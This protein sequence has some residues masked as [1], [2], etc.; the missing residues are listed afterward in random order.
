M[1]L[2]FLTVPNLSL[3]QTNPVSE[4][5]V[6]DIRKLALENTPE[7]DRSLHIA[8]RSLFT[9]HSPLDI[10]PYQRI[11]IFSVLT[12]AKA[13]PAEDAAEI[14]FS[15][16]GETKDHLIHVMS[17]VTDDNLKMNAMMQSLCKQTFLGRIFHT[18]RISLGSLTAPCITSGR[19][20]QVAEALEQAIRYTSPRAPQVSE[21]T[22]AAL[23]AEAVRNPAFPQALQQYPHLYQA[24]KS[25]FPVT[26][27]SLFSAPPQRAGGR[28][29]SA[30]G[31]S[32]QENHVTDHIV[33]RFL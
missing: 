12:E 24:V 9:T 30:S 20:L 16:L 19:L 11:R 32:D 3:R 33:S 27:S 2:R 29:G 21:A 26:T 31:Q 28:A 22:A 10:A 8:L 6:E 14:P 7:A 15:D 25:C 23:R 5:L 17:L 1:F 18:P 13:W 4:V